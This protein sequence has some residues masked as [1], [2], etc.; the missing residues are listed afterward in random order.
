MSQ[1]T[2]F[3]VAAEIRRRLPGVRSAKV[4]K[5]LY[6]AQARHLGRYGEAMYSEQI[7]AWCKGPVVAEVWRT[8][9]YNRPTA[10]DLTS[11]TLT[12]EHLATVDDVMEIY[13]AIDDSKLIKAARE[14]APWIEAW[15]DR[16]MN[17]ICEPIGHDSMRRAYQSLSLD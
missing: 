5:L 1:T 4:Q 10:L 3:E 15:E 2:A 14:E 13:S 8:E 9:R 16:A 12:L 6:Y 17:S 7:E 11:S